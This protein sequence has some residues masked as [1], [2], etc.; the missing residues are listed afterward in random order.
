MVKPVQRYPEGTIFAV[1]LGHDLFAVGLVSRRK[2]RSPICFGYFFGPPHVGLPRVEDLP[3][4]KPDNAIYKFRF[5]HLGLATGRWPVIGTIVPWNRGEWPLPQFYLHEPLKGRTWIVRYSED[6]PAEFISQSDVDEVPDG[7]IE[8]GLDGAGAV[9]V[10]LRQ[11]LG[12]S[13]SH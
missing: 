12:L 1:P 5:G 11:I 9:E 10:G 13:K 3:K 2:G 8:G 6:N 7:A 4:L